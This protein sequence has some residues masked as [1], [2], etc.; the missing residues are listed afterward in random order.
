MSQAVIDFCEGLKTALLGIED[1]LGK[2]KRSLESGT[3][4]VSGEAKEHVEKAAEQLEAFKAHAGV[5]A[6]AIRADLPHQTAVVK[7]KLKEFSQEAQVAMRHAVIF[8][9][10]TASKGAEGAADA[11]EASAKQAQKVAQD[12]R[13]DTAVVA[14][15]PPP[16]TPP[17]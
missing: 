14:T 16:A 11:L 5:L 1:R 9:A 12:L 17:A 6:Q 8:L 15:E 4:Q 3:A 10:E 13:H 2:A 7:E